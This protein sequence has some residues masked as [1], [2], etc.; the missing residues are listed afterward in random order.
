MDK[1]QDASNFI[2]NADGSI[3][4]LGL[5]PHE[6]APT[7]LTVGD[8]ERVSQVSAY[9]DRIELKKQKRELCTHTGVYQGK[10]ISVISTGMGTD[11]I[12]I[13]L[14]EL[15]ALFH[16][17]LKNGE[18][19]NH[20]QTLTLIRMGTSG[21]IQP[22]IPVDSIVMSSI[23][24]GVDNLMGFY[25]YKSAVS[26]DLDHALE[27]FFGRHFPKISMYTARAH[28]DLISHFSNSDFNLG[29]NVTHPGFYGPQGRQGRIPIAFPNWIATLQ[30]FEHPK[31]RLTNFDME[32]SGILALAHL[33]GHRALSLN[34]IL[35]N[36]SA[37]TFS[38]HPDKAI[39][40]MII[41]TLDGV[42]AL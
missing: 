9:F 2:C 6:V 42:A 32:T 8:P 18:P 15:D 37:G 33:L 30:A 16:V 12:D 7:V 39:Q 27:N 41:A 17:D 24:L 28:P 34:A 23:A 19:K 10:R 31:G 36:R 21:A 26:H 5:Q 14:N 11:N 22:D 1:Q 13:V 4:H 20:F 40:K 29:I 35:A 3:Y 25:N 38:K